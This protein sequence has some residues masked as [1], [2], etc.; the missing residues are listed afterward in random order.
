MI[1]RKIKKIKVMRRKKLL[2]EEVLRGSKEISLNESLTIY[3]SYRINPDKQSKIF[4]N[5][6]KNHTC[7]LLP[8]SKT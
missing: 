8:H 4:R 1:G 5:T 6:I 2:S 7:S 3:I